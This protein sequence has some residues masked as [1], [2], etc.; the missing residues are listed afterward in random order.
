LFLLRESGDD[1]NDGKP[2]SWRK[3]RTARGSPRTPK[4]SDL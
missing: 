4:C 3:R 1:F 2:K